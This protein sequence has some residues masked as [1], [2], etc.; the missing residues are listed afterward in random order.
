MQN[1]FELFE[2]VLALRGVLLQIMGRREYLPQHLLTVTR[3][4]S[5]AG[6]FQIASNSI[7][8]VPFGICFLQGQ[9]KQ[10]LDVVPNLSWRLEESKIL[11]NQGERDKA[12]T[13]GK[14]LIQALKDGQ[15][16][17]LL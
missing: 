11:W 6:R 14:L 17:K 13:G 3:L 4:A 1:N 12:I 5:K 9:L 10:N 16:G 15:K 8:Q 7:Y 2:P